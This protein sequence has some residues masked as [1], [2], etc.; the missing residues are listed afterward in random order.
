MSLPSIQ[1]FEQVL[2]NILSPD[3]EKRKQ[4]EADFNTAKSNPNYCVSSLLQIMR[5]SPRQEVNIRFL[6]KFTNL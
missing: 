5:Q 3:N 4:A 2:S 6:C 1:Q